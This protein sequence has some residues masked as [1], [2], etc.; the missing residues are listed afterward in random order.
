MQ[1]RNPTKTNPFSSVGRLLIQSAC[2]SVATDDARD[3]ASW[4]DGSGNQVCRAVNGTPTWLAR[5][6]LMLRAL[7]WRPPLL[8]TLV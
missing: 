6:Q 8:H 5:P 1:G 4:P 3:V 2:E 7:F